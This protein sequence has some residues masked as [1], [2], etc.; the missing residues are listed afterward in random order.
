MKKLRVFLIGILVA[1]MMGSCATAQ[2]NGNAIIS[3]SDTLHLIW[4]KVNPS[5]QGEVITYNI[6][7]SVGSMTDTVGV[8]SD[9][10]CVVELAGYGDGYY[11]FG[12]Q[13]ED[14]AHNISEILWCDSAANLAGTWILLRDTTPPVVSGGIRSWFK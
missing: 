5:Y 3:K 4:D 14:I 1:L 8:F 12:V 6:F 10:T 9:T 2:I 13:A 11:R 7:I